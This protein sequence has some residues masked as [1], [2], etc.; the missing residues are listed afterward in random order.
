MSINDLISSL[1]D[2]G[3]DDLSAIAPPSPTDRPLSPDVHAATL[4]LRRALPRRLVLRLKRGASTALVIL[5]PSGDWCGPLKHAICALAGPGTAVAYS[6]SSGSSASLSTLLYYVRPAPDRSGRPDATGALL[7]GLLGRGGSAIGLAP[8]PDLLPRQLVEAADATIQIDGLT[9]RDLMKVIRATTLCGHCPRIDDRL[10][11]GLSPTQVAMAVRA[12]ATPAACLKRLQAISSRPLGVDL[13]TAPYL[14]DLAGYGAARDWGLALKADVERRR[15]DPSSVSLDTITRSLLL[16]G[17]PGTGK[18]LYASALASS[19][20][21]PLIVS[22]YADWQASGTGHLG[23]VMTALRACFANAKTAAQKSGVGAVLLLDEID[24]IPSR[25]STARNDHQDWWTSIQ[26][27]LLTLTEQNSPARIGV[28][29]IAATNYPDRLDS[30][31]TRSG[32]LDR[33]I[34]LAL[35]GPDDLAA[36]ARTHLGN[37]LADADLLPLARLGAGMTGADMARIVR[38]AR[39]R[40][41]DASRDLAIDDLVAGLLPPETRPHAVLIRTARHEAAHAVVGLALGQQELVSI[42]LSTPH[43]EGVARFAP[44]E[45]LAQTRANLEAL[46]I[47]GLAG[48]A[49]DALFGEADTG[50]TTDL[51]NATSVVAD[52]RLRL[53]LTD[54]LV[55]LGPQADAVDLLR[56]DPTLRAA[57]EADLQ[58]LY[59]HAQA[60]VA[61]RR[62]DVEMVAQAL[63]RRRFLSGDDVRA[64]LAR[65]RKAD[66]MRMIDQGGDHVGR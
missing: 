41:R 22:S 8:D 64:I 7:P 43:G 5:A 66:A 21:I 20:G 38:D 42:S 13:S 60:M 53:G 32:R 58:R 40:A 2:D 36:M 48:R 44:I 56:I 14:E 17:P 28:I 26:N 63:V 52:M 1:D 59:A 30:A 23:D 9:G 10:A 11:A 39:Q 16:A 18:T 24:S 6:S 3:S 19:C 4:A 27:A 51:A 34:T 62:L 57:V 61:E 31:F 12:N 37:V 47:M 49:A 25:A 55:S 33:T 50:A 29:L 54:H 45:D 46:V 15:A 35:P 65:T